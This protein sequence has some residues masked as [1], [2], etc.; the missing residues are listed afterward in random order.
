MQFNIGNKCRIVKEQTILITLCRDG[1]AARMRED[2]LWDSRLRNSAI[3]LLL[4][5]VRWPRLAKE[6]TRAGPRSEAEAGGRGN[7]GH[8]GNVVG[9]WA[10]A[11]DAGARR[12]DP[13][14]ICDK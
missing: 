12:S 4:S 1:K 5:S 14:R 3:S 8:C 9:A 2:V 11:G 10:A 13:E 7:G 6:G